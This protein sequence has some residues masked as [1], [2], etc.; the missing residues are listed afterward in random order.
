MAESRLNKQEAADY[1]RITVRQLQRL[2]SQGRISH[3]R[4]RGP[5][6]DV[7]L[8]DRKE[9][10]RYVTERD[11]QVYVPSRPAGTSDISRVSGQ[12]QD[13]SL[14]RIRPTLEAFAKVFDP[15]KTLPALADLAQKHWLTRQEAIR[16]SG[17]PRKDIE[18]ALRKRKLG[19]KRGGRWLVKRVDLESYTAKWKP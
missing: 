4:V 16:L 13:V 3:T 17:L 6:G 2:M 10:E 19:T 18:E 11:A 8:F 14:A 5:K 9:L 1:L 7:A 15:R 12:S